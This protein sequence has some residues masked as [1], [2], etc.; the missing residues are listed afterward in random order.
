MRDVKLVRFIALVSASNHSPAILEPQKYCSR[1]GCLG[2][3]VKKPHRKMEGVR[4]ILL[5]R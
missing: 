1:P 3:E 2:D 4:Q 5:P